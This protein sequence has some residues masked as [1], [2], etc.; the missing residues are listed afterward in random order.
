MFEFQVDENIK[1]RLPLPH[2]ADELTV[3]VRENLLH[4][5][6]WMPWAVNDYSIQSARD[7]IKQN[8]QAMSDETGL[9]MSIVDGDK[10]IGQ[11][12][13][14]EL[15]RHA[16]STHT[17]YWIA[18][19]AQGRGIVTRCCRVLIAYCFGELNLNRVQIN[20]NTAN[21]KS[22]QVAERLGFQLEGVHRQTELS[23]DGQRGDTAVYGLLKDEWNSAAQNV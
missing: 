6:Q 11:I 22:R 5:Q 13:L 14:H 15:N 8:L 4:L 23:G 12:G 7:Y 10:I 3:V 1:L 9:A 17:G 21:A 19:N 20:C 18:K 16:K 2:H